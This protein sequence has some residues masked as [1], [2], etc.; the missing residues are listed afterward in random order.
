MTSATNATGI[1][2][3]SSVVSSASLTSNSTNRSSRKL[4][5]E[6]GDSFE[7]TITRE[8][9]R[10]IKRERKAQP[11]KNRKVKEGDREREGNNGCV[12]ENIYI[13]CIYIYICR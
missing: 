3:T 12:R 8:D 10:N 1:S 13:I 9:K 5:W 6:S 4:N 2:N 7:N 11:K